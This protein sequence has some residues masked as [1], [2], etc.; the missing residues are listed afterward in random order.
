MG[1]PDVDVVWVMDAEGWEGV[2]T[3][4]SSSTYC[5]IDTEW[6]DVGSGPALIQIAFAGSQD[7]R[8]SCFLVD[9]WLGEGS[10]E[11][12]RFRHVVAAGLLKV[13]SLESL[14][15]VGWSFQEDAKRLRELCGDDH[16]D[17]NFSVE[18]L[19][20]ISA[21]LLPSSNKSGCMEGLAV[22]CARFLGKPLDKTE[23]CSDWRT[24]PL[25]ESQRQYAALDA[26]VLLDL[27]RV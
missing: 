12:R 20:P 13:F 19:Q 7:R 17:C 8:Q 3:T 23:Q 10:E 15:I 18:D 2:E 22:T 24:R 9:T 5:A 25:K 11:T 21:S 1:S 14:Q 26:I 27:H 16:C 6:W 4:A